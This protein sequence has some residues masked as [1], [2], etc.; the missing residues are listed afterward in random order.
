MKTLKTAIIILL[1][2]LIAGCS[3]SMPSEEEN[4]VQKTI[5][6]LD[7]QAKKSHEEQFKEEEEKPEESEEENSEGV[8]DIEVVEEDEKDV[9]DEDED[10]ETEKEVE[11]KTAQ[12][13]SS[14]DQ[15]DPIKEEPKEE[16]KE[17][18]KP[19]PEPPKEEPPKEEPPKEE[20]PKEEPKPKPEPKPEPPREEPKPEPPKE[21]PKPEPP[22]EEVVGEKTTT[23][24]SSDVQRL[25]DYGYLFDPSTLPA[26]LVEEIGSREDEGV[27]EFLVKHKKLFH[28]EFIVANK[29]AYRHPTG[30]YAIRGVAIKYEDGQR[31]EADA[32]FYIK[33]VLSWDTGESVVSSPRPTELISNWKKVQ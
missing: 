10:E 26:G 24:T 23:L 5:N 27:A 31:Y 1:M 18:P 30:A 2:L 28:Y 8:E 33:K 4:D 11:E 19:K 13:D 9:S 16:S 29:T 3:Q 22:K 21:E 6:D 14:T 20:P 7:R 25:K 12:E 32:E 15:S 17:E